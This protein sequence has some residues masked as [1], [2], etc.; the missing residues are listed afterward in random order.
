MPTQVGQ[1]TLKDP[2]IPN[3]VPGSAR[4]SHDSA[5][6]GEESP[7]YLAF[8]AAGLVTTKYRLDGPEQIECVAPNTTNMGNLMYRAG[9]CIPAL[10]T[11][12]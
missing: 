8:K 9:L 11:T 4:G 7:A 10:L 1:A 5:P 2:L 6:K 3:E 12:P